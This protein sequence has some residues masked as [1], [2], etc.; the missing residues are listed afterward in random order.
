MKP[1]HPTQCLRLGVSFREQAPSHAFELCQ[2]L[3]A[4]MPSHHFNTNNR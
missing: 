3:S 1:A 2:W 4:S